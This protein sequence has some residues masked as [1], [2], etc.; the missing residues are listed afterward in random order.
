MAMAY[1]EEGR[2]LYTELVPDPAEVVRHA[3]WRDAALHRAIPY[4]QYVRCSADLR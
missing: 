1:D 3:H 2:F 4:Q